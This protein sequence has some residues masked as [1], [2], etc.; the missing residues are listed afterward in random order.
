[1]CAII[2]FSE[3]IMRKIIIHFLFIYASIP[4]TATKAFAN[5]ELSTS[6]AKETD[7]AVHQLYHSLQTNP[8]PKNMAARL[9]V[10]S[11]QWLHRPYTLTALSLKLFGLIGI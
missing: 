3:K 8:T 7:R 4:L 2:L 1:M 9:N 10:I 6:Q 5:Q 11:K